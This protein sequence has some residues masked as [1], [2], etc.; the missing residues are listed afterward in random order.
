[1][2]GPILTGATSQSALDWQCF[3]F[4]IFLPH[5]NLKLISINKFVVSDLIPASTSSTWISDF[6]TVATENTLLA[7]F[8][9]YLIQENEFVAGIGIAVAITFAQ[10]NVLMDS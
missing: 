4:Y 8:P 9:E 6:T 10:L 1:M 3:T 5:F 7:A 2:T